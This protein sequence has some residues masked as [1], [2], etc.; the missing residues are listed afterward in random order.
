LLILR[1]FLKR[2]AKMKKTS[3][4]VATILRIRTHVMLAGIMLLATGCPELSVTELTLVPGSISEGKFTLLARAE[5]SYEREVC[6]LKENGKL[7]DRDCEPGLESWGG[8][9]LIGVWL[10]EGWKVDGA[11]LIEASED[12]PEALLPMEYLAKAFPPTF[13]YAPGKWWPFITECK[14]IRDGVTVYNIEFDVS[15]DASAE[16]IGVGV[17]L[18]FY[19]ADEE[20]K[21]MSF[22]GLQMTAEIN[23]TSG[24]IESREHKAQEV[25]PDPVQNEKVKWCVSVPEPVGRGPRGCSCNE[26]GSE[27]PRPGRL[28]SV[29]HGLII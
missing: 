2:G 12:E 19:D 15:G 20:E 13:P 25:F 8:N 24:T 1:I 9:G 23:L 7:V 10:P 28:L 3:R 4:S 22:D 14:E 29:L 18:T 26:T 21:G 5:A 6:E 27:N 16:T 11:R 17:A